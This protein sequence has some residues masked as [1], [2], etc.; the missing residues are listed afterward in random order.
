MFEL[1][2]RE[3]CGHGQ[4][5]GDHLFDLPPYSE[6]ELG[7]F[8][9]V[10]VHGVVMSSEWLDEHTCPGG[11]ETV[12]D[13]DTEVFPNWRNDGFRGITVQDVIDALTKEEE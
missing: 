4:W 10:L 6:I 2:L 5:D 13:P 11:R 8:P 9:R 7:R 3:P 1:V 12:L